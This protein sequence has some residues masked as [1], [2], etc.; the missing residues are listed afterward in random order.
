MPR[1]NRYDRGMLDEAKQALA[2][3]SAGKTEALTTKQAVT[4]LYPELKHQH[5]H[6]CSYEELAAALSDT[7]IQLS[8]STLAQYMREAGKAKTKRKPHRKTLSKTGLSTTHG[9]RDGA[10]KSDTPSPASW[11]KTPMT[12]ATTTEGSAPHTSARFV[13]IDDDSL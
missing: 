8:G 5:D 1:I 9:A 3:V 7:G 2:Q 6:G 13:D 10:D 11:R 4:A 12:S